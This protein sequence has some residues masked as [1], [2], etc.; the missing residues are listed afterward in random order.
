MKSD[1]GYSNMST[2]ECFCTCLAIAG[3]CFIFTLWT[4]TKYGVSTP[5]NMDC[6]DLVIRH[7][8]GSDLKSFVDVRDSCAESLNVIQPTSSQEPL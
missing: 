3:V 6:P 2:F 7:G 8:I 4:P 5:I 1:I